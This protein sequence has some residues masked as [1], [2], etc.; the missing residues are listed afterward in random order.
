MLRIFTRLFAHGSIQ[1]SDMQ[2]S[3]GTS[4]CDGGGGVSFFGAE[5]GNH[6]M[7]QAHF[8]LLMNGE[9]NTKWG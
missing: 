9:K 1:T 2:K 3:S 4:D 8:G 5:K 6:R 7:H